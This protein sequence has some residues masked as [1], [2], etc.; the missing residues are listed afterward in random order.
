MSIFTRIFAAVVTLPEGEDARGDA[1]RMAHAVSTP[2]DWLSQAVEHHEGLEQ[3]FANVWL[4]L[5]CTSRTSAFKQL[6]ILLTVHSIAEEAVIYPALAMRRDKSMSFEAYDEQAL[7]K[8]QMAVLDRLNP[9][10]RPFIDKLASL[11]RMVMDHIYAEEGKRFLDLK[12]VVSSYDQAIMTERYAEEYDRYAGVVG[13]VNDAA[14]AWIRPR[15][16]NAAVNLVA[17]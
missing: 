4:A 17:A 13:P 14:V 10:S 12:R 8:V 15:Q 2:G 16:R 5:D 7:I 1:R 3:A 6:G 9:M 11:E